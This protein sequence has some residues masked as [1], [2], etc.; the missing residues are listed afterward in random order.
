MLCSLHGSKLKWLDGSFWQRHFWLLASTALPEEAQGG[1][2][3]RG[4]L[5]GA[6]ERTGQSFLGRKV[7]SWPV[8]D[9]ALSLM[10]VPAGRQGAGKI[11]E[12]DAFYKCTSPKIDRCFADL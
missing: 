1:M 3:G 12:G 8:D 2:R 11:T 10:V 5:A 4:R 6:K 7:V 9:G